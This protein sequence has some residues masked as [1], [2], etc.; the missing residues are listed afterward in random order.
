MKIY[1]NIS[2]PQKVLILSIIICIIT[3]LPGTFLIIFEK[4]ITSPKVTIKP[5]SKIKARDSLG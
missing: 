1:R 4:P 5:F 3:Y 2:D